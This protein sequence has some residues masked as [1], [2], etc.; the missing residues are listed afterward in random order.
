M[1]SSNRRNP[2]QRYGGSAGSG[3]IGPQ[4]RGTLPTGRG[5]VGASGGLETVATADRRD[6]E[7]KRC[8]PRVAT[9][10][11]EILGTVVAHANL[12]ELFAVRMGFTKVGAQSTLP[13]VYVLHVILRLGD[14][15][16]DAAIDPLR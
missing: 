14:G 3:E 12:N 9:L 6:H 4:D 7:M 16:V 11:H 13:V 5:S 2:V 1:S 10:V 15:H 8:V